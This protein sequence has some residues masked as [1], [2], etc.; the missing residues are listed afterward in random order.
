MRQASSFF[1]F[2]PASIY[3]KTK[4]RLDFSLLGFAGISP[5]K[6]LGSE[7]DKSTMESSPLNYC[8]CTSNLLPTHSHR[9]ALSFPQVSIS[10]PLPGLMATY[11]DITNTFGG[12]TS[13]PNLG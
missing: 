11:Y 1:K 3:F 8:S 4:N 6:F 12:H 9:P 7:V 2:F 5:W 10:V 13:T